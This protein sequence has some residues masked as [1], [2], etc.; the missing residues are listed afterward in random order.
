MST[1]QEPVKTPDGSDADG[2][3]AELGR[4]R[5]PWSIVIQIVGFAAGLAL[6]VW[7]V[8]RALTPQNT[9]AL[10][11]LARTP[12][13]VVAGLLGLTALSL[14]LNAGAFFVTIRP[15][16]PLGF[17]G[18]LCVNILATFLNYLPFKMGL[19]ARFVI[20]ARRDRLPLMTT[21]AWMA[22][23]GVVVLAVMIPL[24]G[25]SFWRQNVDAAWTIA[26]TGGVV[27]TLLCVL[28]MAKIFAHARGL[29]RVHR[30]ADGISP[31]LFGRLSRTPAFVNL[32]SAFAMLDHPTTLWAGA[33]LRVGD[34]GVQAARFV[35]AAH[36]AGQTLS[37]EAAIL[38]ACVY[39]LIG[40]LSPGGTL[41]AREGGTAG[42]GHLLAIPG[43]NTEG[44]AL[45]ALV[46]GGAELIVNFVCASGAILYLRPDRLLRREAKPSAGHDSGAG[47]VR[48]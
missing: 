46:V 1:E 45:V 22:A 3:Q 16:R 35:L 24:A 48:S 12:W 20:H 28:V 40:V 21:G 29:A 47:S 27:A 6:L 39:F 36:A 25:A 42:L 10:E 44:F 15:V 23:V 33:L 37:W 31:R 19:I 4:S 11:R 30:I 14:L 38:A 43:M 32:H 9:D 5:G 26:A 7:C 8:S 34:I 2:S 13:E 18:V 41:G 17:A